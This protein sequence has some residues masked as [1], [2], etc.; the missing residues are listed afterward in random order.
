M[1]LSKYIAYALPEG[2]HELYAAPQAPQ[3][4]AQSV[5]E[6]FEAWAMD[7]YGCHRAN[8]DYFAGVDGFVI[9]QARGQSC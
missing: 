8:V 1:E 7:F 3:S 4:E 6:S 2:M 9:W 5:R